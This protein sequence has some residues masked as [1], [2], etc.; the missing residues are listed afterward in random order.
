M[1][2]E[3]YKLGV[4]SIDIQHKKLFEM[5]EELLKA[6]DQKSEPEVFKKIIGFLKEYVVVHFKTE[7]AYQASI[8]YIGIKE[9]IKQHQAFT[10]LVLSFEKRLEQSAYDLT[11][12]KELAGTL[13]AWLI[14]HVA[15]A[16]QKIILKNLRQEKEIQN[17]KIVNSYIDSF[18]ESM[19]DVLIKMAGLDSSN[20]DIRKKNL[21][22]ITGD[23]IITVDLI[24]DFQGSIVFSF[25][26]KFAVKL[27]EAMTFM[28][29]EEIDGL[30]C[31]ALA[32]MSNITCGNI[33]ILLSKKGV[34]VDIKTPLIVSEKEIEGN[35]LEGLHI[36][37]KF[38][39]LEI[40]IIQE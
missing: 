7:E 36:A 35:V 32:E 24:G 16:D 8:Q 2:K 20:I 6:I 33:T 5:T 27:F 40:T 26:K 34:N 18:E 37:T 3:S 11:I 28:V 39:D 23:V 19:K 25:S 22:K 38:G 30:V 9:H 1:W 21:T 17:E 13:T 31:S 14:Y 10:N 15:D 12:L 4:E 29:L